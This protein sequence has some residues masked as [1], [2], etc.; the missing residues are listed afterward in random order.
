MHADHHGM[1]AEQ[2][3]ELTQRERQVLHLAADGL[4]NAEIAEA[5]VLSV[6]TVERHLSNAYFKLGISGKTARTAAVA[7]LLRE[8][9][10]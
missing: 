2:A 5:L 1:S 6:R 3:S 7:S 4:S 9:L 10:A 8:D